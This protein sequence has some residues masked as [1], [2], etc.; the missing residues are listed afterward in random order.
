MVSLVAIMGKVDGER[1]KEAA[2]A[3][4]NG[5]AETFECAITGAAP[6]GGVNRI[7]FKGSRAKAL[8]VSRASQP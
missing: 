5:T 7:R 1:N 4:E 6:F 8:S 2:H 3:W